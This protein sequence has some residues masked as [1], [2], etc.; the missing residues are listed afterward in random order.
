[1]ITKF[2]IVTEHNGLPR[3]I[4]DA[5]APFATKYRIAASLDTLLR[6]PP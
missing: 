1:L 2:Y 3:A 6:S 5:V 4:F